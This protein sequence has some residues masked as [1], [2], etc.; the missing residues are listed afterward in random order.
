MSAVEASLKRLGTDWIDLYQVHRP[1]PLTSI[2]ETL[3]AL[4]DLV[5][6]GKVRYVGCSNFPAWQVVEAHWTARSMSLNG[7]VSCQDEYSL[8]SRGIERD[9]LPAMRAYGL[10]LLPY[11]PL[12]SG[13]ADR[14]IPARRACAAR[15]AALLRQA[16]RKPLSH[17][18]PFRHRGS[19]WSDAAPSAVR[20]LL[21]I[22]IGWLAQSPCVSSVIAGAT[23]PEQLEAT[24]AHCSARFRPKELA[25]VNRLTG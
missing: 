23:R 3:R 17:R 12:A 14:E 6:Q 9:L 18:C 11:F 10:G 25:E 1:D 24:P 4:D 20:T 16:A 15:R 5:R 7:F 8:L 21:E 2:E 22:S 13:L 19:G